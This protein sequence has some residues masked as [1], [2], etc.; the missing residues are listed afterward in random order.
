M[1]RTVLLL[2][3]PVAPARRQAD[4]TPDIYRDQGSVRLS[5]SQYPFVLN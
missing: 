5:T 1:S 4:R 3:S 2:S